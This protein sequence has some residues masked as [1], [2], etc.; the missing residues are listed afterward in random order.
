[1]H[2]YDVKSGRDYSTGM[3][4]VCDNELECEIFRFTQ[5]QRKTFHHFIEAT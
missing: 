3:G 2:V 5:F 1:M 4:Y